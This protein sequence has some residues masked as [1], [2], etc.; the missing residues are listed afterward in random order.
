MHTIFNKFYD[1]YGTSN[2]DNV[3]VLYG[4]TPSP[5]LQQVTNTA[6]SA[7]GWVN[8]A[9]VQGLLSIDGERHL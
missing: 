1:N 7:G 9:R 4:R 2:A 3:A 6:R 8:E 5:R